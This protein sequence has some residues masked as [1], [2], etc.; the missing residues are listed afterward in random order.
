[1]QRTFIGHP[2][3]MRKKV[4]NKRSTIQIW[5]SIIIIVSI[6]LL[7][8]R[9]KLCEYTDCTTFHSVRIRC[10]SCFIL[11]SVSCLILIV[12][13]LSVTSC[14]VS[15]RWDCPHLCLIVS[16]HVNQL[17][18]PFLQ[19]IPLPVLIA[20]PA[21]RPSSGIITAYWSLCFGGLVTFKRLCLHKHV[22]QVNHPLIGSTKFRLRA[23]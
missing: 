7:V 22:K 15:V 4:E 6:Y 5:A 19:L 17:C 9:T 16:P 3:T 20:L 10:Q 2:L 11:V 23:F 14:Q 1:M 8:R 21:Y 12:C 18:F 13:C